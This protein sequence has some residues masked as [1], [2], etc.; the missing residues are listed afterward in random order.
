LLYCGA[1]YSFVSLGKPHMAVWAVAAC[2]ASICVS[3]V[4][5]K[6]ETAVAGGKLSANEVNR[7]FQDGLLRFEI[8]MFLLVIGLLADKV[9][10]AV[11]V[12][13]V[14]STYTAFERLIKISRKLQ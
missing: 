3:Y 4:K 12:I 13:A 10:I 2:G 1:A 5:A 7:L 14:M 6:G 9:I 8:R 11:I